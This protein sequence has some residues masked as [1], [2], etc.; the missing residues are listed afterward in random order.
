MAEARSKAGI[1]L[2]EYER[3][4]KA[5]VKGQVNMVQSLL[6]KIYQGGGYCFS[7]LPAFR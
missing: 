5:V 1:D 6:Q 4:Q 3:L 7:E 2:N